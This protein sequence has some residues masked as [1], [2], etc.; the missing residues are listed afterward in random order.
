MLHITSIQFNNYKCFHRFS[1]TL[2]SFN[3][4]VGPNNAGKSTV[5]GACKILAEGIKK[6]RA[7]KPIYTKDYKRVAV[8]GY[9]IDLELV[10]I[11][12]E[13][14]IYNYLE[15]EVTFVEFKLS[16][17]ATL[18]LI[19]PEARKCFFYHKSE[20]IV[21]KSPKDF[22]QWV[23]L[24]IGFVPVLGPVDHEEKLYQK[25]AA[26]QALLAYTASRNFRNIWYHYNENFEEFQQQIRATWPGMDIERP[27]V[28]TSGKDPLLFMFC[29][30]ERMP[31]EIFWSGFGFQVWCQMLTYIIQNKN[32]SLFIIDEPDIYLHSELQRQ[33]L[34]ILRELGPNIIIATHSTEMIS[35]AEMSEL[36]VINKRNQSA[37]RIK[38]PSKL[39]DI[40]QVLGSNLNP[41][42]TQI[43]K[44]KR[45]L[46]VEGKDFSLLSKF[47]RILHQDAVANRKD[48]AVIPV[49]GFNPA[50]LKPLKEGIEMTIGSG[51][52]SAVIFDR[53]Y[54]SDKEV[55]QVKND[56][57]AENK[58]VHIHRCKELENFLIVPDAIEKALRERVKE[59]NRRTGSTTEFRHNIHEVF[60]DISNQFKYPVQAQLSSHREKFAKSAGGADLAVIKEDILR[61]FDEIWDN[62]LMRYTIVP[63]KDFL[64]SVNTWAQENYKV[65][66]TPANIINSLSK[67]S[68]P[69]EMVALIEQIEKFRNLPVT[70]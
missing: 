1:V 48:F 43:A 21:I 33:L 70:D 41:V 2:D 9:D 67:I 25:E 40:F 52:L 50:A 35:E 60:K 53:D 29:P 23:N 36:L 4:L 16:D 7:K 45:V 13:N 64:S 37:R 65:S 42:M 24:D 61:E 49:D 63:G 68:V 27:Y 57:A 17:D 46:F 11:A 56:V 47:A 66:I 28:D 12:T 44:S 69:A 18:T 54:R 15:N 19:F 14:V 39:R 38:D 3:I 10:P 51:I 32:A 20:K 26:R 62:L 34:G 55:E 8:L 6:A 58:F 59:A 30:E 5:I 31:R 22:K